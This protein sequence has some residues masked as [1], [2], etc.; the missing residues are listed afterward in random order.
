MLLC[1]PSPLSAYYLVR[2]VEKYLLDID[3]LQSMN[4]SPRNA[5][6]LCR[7]IQG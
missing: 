7:V 5:I 3:D 1:F 4:I 6:N 2:S